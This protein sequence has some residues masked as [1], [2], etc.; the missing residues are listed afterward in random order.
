MR[1]LFI[2]ASK[3]NRVGTGS[4][5]ALILNIATFNIISEYGRFR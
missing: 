1:Q 5:A 2:L 3:Q 4:N